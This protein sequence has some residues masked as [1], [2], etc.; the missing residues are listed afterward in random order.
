MG[1][2][3]LIAAGVALVALLGWLG[4]RAEQELDGVEP[5][6]EH[7]RRLRE[8]MPGYLLRDET[9]PAPGGGRR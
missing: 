9:P 1:W 2:P 5:R 7:L 6:L 8:L 3:L 4:W